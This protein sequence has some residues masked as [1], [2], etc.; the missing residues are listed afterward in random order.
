MNG[1]I[2]AFT[3]GEVKG[4]ERMVREYKNNIYIL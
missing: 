1:L 3:L 4:D 2:R